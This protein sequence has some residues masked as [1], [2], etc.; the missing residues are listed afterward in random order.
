MKCDKEHKAFNWSQNVLDPSL[1]ELH[2]TRLKTYALKSAV[3][4]K[5]VDF[6]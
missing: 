5:R 4:M 3:G 2:G 6:I 1:I